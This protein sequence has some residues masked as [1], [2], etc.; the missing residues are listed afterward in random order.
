MQK[1]FENA[2]T[3]LLGMA[4]ELYKNTNHECL[5][6]DEI[7]IGEPME[8][9][10]NTTKGE[11][12]FLYKT[13]DDKRELFCSPG[14]FLVK[15]LAR[16]TQFSAIPYS[17]YYNNQTMENPIEKYFKTDKADFN[18]QKGWL[19][20]DSYD[21]L[22]PVLPLGIQNQI[23]IVGT[24]YDLVHSIDGKTVAAFATFDATVRIHYN[25]IQLIF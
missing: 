14:L 17:Y 6:Q 18:T 3:A 16:R 8:F 13:M 19:D 10:F 12:R 23:Q 9:D 5:F 11:F 7:E 20:A 22:A 1:N 2:V 21:Y 24:Y 25:T 15:E 4:V